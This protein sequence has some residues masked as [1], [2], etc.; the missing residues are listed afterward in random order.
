MN[1]R[2]RL[3]FMCESSLHNAVYRTHD[4]CVSSVLNLLSVEFSMF[5]NCQHRVGI[6]ESMKSVECRMFVNLS[7]LPNLNCQCRTGIMSKGNQ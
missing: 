1:R 4:V 6:V 5:V 3:E 7:S 2:C